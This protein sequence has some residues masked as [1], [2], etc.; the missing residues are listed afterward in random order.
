MIPLSIA[1]VAAAVGGALHDVSD[2]EAVVRGPVL[3]DSR[4]AVDGALFVAVKGERTDGHAYAAAAVDAGA[5]V[6]LA[7]RPVGVPAVVVDDPIAAMGRLARAVLDRLD[8][9]TVVGI[10]GSSGKTSTKDLLAQVLETAGSTVAPK[11]SFNNEIGV[12]LTVLA[13]DESTR[14]LVVEMGA[15][16]LGH[17]AELCRIAPPRVAVVLNIGSAHAGEFGSRDATATAKRELVEAL[18]ADGV[19]VLNADD[20][21]VLA[22]AP[23]APGSVVSFGTA[24]DA[25]VRAESIELDAKGRA[26]FDLVT[27]AGRARVQLLVVGAHQVSNALATAAV[28][29]ALQ[30]PVDAVAA[31]LSSAR[32]RSRW[33][34]EVTERSDGVTVVNDAYNANPESVRAAL[35]ALASMAAGRRTWAVLGEMLELGVCARGVVR[36]A[37]DAGGAAVGEEPVLVAD[38]GAALALLQSQLRSGDVILVKASRRAGLE[39]VAQGLTEEVTA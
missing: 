7:A 20:P 38:A 24:A 3:V 27:A 1:A 11:E 21:L 4:A 37:I 25:D 22:M 12:P 14:Y 16:G 28:A 33:R 9:I 35:N 31:A 34:M 17:I 19:A 32:P 8:D 23:A 26:S 39:R 6:V 10:T 36:A 2:P 30:L 18:S 29:G 5:V 13:A 15:R